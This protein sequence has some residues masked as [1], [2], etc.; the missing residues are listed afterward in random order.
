MASSPQ[1]QHSSATTLSITCQRH[2]WMLCIREALC[3]RPTTRRIFR[4]STVSCMRASVHWRSISL[5]HIVPHTFIICVNA[6][7]HS[8][9]T[10]AA[11]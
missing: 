9:D 4:F 10:S 3:H 6:H 7:R 8:E 5:T 2:D 1:K 11:A